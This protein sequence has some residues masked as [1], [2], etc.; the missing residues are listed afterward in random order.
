[1][2]QAQWFV[3]IAELGIELLQTSVILFISQKNLQ[4]NKIEL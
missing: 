1:V 4:V 2:Y 3:V